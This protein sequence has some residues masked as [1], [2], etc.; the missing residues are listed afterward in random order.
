MAPAADDVAALRAELQALKSDYSTRVDALET[1]I[2]QL[3]AANAAAADA[4]WPRRRA[5]AAPSNPC[6]ARQAAAR[7]A[8]NPAI[9]LILGGSFT[10]T[11]RDPADW[12]IG[13]LRAGRRRDRSRRAQLQSRRVRADVQRQHRSVFLGA[14]D[15]G[16]H[17]RERDRSRGGVLPHHG[18]ARRAHRQGRTLLLGLRLSQ[19][20][21]RACLGLRRPA[22]GLPGH[23]RRPVQAERPAG[24][25]AGAHRSVP[26]V[27]RGDRQR[28]WL[29]RDA[30][31]NERLQW[32]HLVRACR[33]RPRRL[34]QLARRRRLARRSSAEDREGGIADAIGDPL[35]DFFTRRL[36]TP[37]S[38]T[39]CSSGRRRRAGSS[40]CRASTCVA[41]R[42][43]RSPTPM[44]C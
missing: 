8:F 7:S 31:A 43:A 13:W 11:S 20:S 18:A 26:R 44:A 36:A 29:P 16:D 9:S 15:R 12:H 2:K 21:A 34:H 39:A 40:R 32:R 41:A 5:A 4:T 24:E 14:A 33:R 22:A 35:F 42:A 19:R 38:S 3:E 37:G 17:R 6:Q 1:R 23:V 25:V 28:R 10:G 30:A 27:R